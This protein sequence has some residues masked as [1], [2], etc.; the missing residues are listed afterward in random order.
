V[1]DLL[2]MALLLFFVVGLVTAFVFGTDG[3][4]NDADNIK[5]KTQ[6]MLEQAQTDMDSYSDTE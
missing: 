5:T 3:F 2:A 4:K 6:T 1:K